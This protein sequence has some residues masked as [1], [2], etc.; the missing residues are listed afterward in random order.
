MSL[1]LATNCNQI[2]VGVGLCGRHHTCCALQVCTMDRSVPKDSGEDEGLNF[3][4]CAGQWEGNQVRV[5][6]STAAW[7]LYADMTFLARPFAPTL[8]SQGWVVFSLYWKLLSHKLG[9]PD[10]GG[11]APEVIPN[12]ILSNGPKA[13]HLRWR[14]PCLTEVLLQRANSL[15]NQ[16]HTVPL[17]G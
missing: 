12:G 1:R 11:G 16:G 8:E 3:P 15:P 6:G 10:C 9:V 4:V 7:M 5:L 14:P 2:K 17:Q 13:P